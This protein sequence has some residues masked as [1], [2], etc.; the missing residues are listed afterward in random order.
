ML[1]RSHEALVSKD[2]FDKA[3][4]RLRMISEK[5]IA[6]CDHTN[7]YYGLARNHLRDKIF[8]GK[9]GSTCYFRHQTTW[10]G[11]R[12][13]DK[14]HV[15]QNNCEGM[16]IPFGVVNKAILDVL[17]LRFDI[18]AERVTKMLVDRRIKRVIVYEGGI[19]YVEVKEK[20]GET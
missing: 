7:E 1:F 2:L 9:C 18:R 10:A 15:R 5:K 17:R 14:K 6:A 3:Q 16:S 12:C 19:V 8:C 11:Y 20:R 13:G 4:Q